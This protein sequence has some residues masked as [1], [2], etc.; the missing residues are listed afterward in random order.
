MDKVDMNMH[1]KKMN[2]TLY[3]P[4]EPSIARQWPNKEA[5]AIWDAIDN[6]GVTNLCGAP[7]VCSTIAEAPQAHRLDR[8]LRITTAA[9][10]IQPPQRPVA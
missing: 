1:V 9:T 7:A 5:D 6:L 8:P 10:F 3:P 4:K 2:G